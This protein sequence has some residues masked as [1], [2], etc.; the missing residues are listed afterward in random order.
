MEITLK[1][2]NIIGG[3][4]EVKVSPELNGLLKPYE[5]TKTYE[6][7][8]ERLSD[9]RGY[10]GLKQ[11]KDG[12]WDIKGNGSQFTKSIEKAYKIESS[13]AIGFGNPI[14]A[15]KTES[16]YTVVVSGPKKEVLAA[17]PTTI[18]D[19]K[20][21][22]KTVGFG[23]QSYRIVFDDPN[24]LAE[25]EKAYAELSDTKYKNNEARLADEARFMAQ[26]ISSAKKV[27]VV[28]VENLSTF[29]KLSAGEQEKYTLNQKEQVEFAKQL[30][31]NSKRYYELALKK[32]QKR[33]V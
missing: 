28:P 10:S 12:I 11:N 17:I 16:S 30:L 8:M 6:F 26:V 20:E 9:G 13:I 25:M 31:D 23:D 22:V 14:D 4:Q 1:Q 33:N 21:Y 24:K 2:Q 27:Y 7:L 5:G 3:K 32:E 18:G 29:K 15:K 19:K